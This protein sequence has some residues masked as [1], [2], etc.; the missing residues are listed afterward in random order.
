MSGFDHDEV[1]TKIGRW[2]PGASAGAA[3][4]D[5]FAFAECAD[6]DDRM[7]DR[8]YNEV[9]EPA[10]PASE[11][12]DRD[13]VRTTWRAPSP[14]VLS[15]LI[16]RGNDPVACAL[17]EWSAA[18]GVLLLSYLAV[19]SDLRGHGLGGALLGEVLPRWH[20]ALT[21]TAILAEVEDPRHHEV[22]PH[23]DPVARLRFYERAGARLLPFSYF[24]PS[25]APGLPR[26]RGMLLICLDARRE[27]I[28]AESVA[29]F[30]DE[31]MASAESAEAARTDPEYLGLR[32]QVLS[33]PGGVPLWPLSRVAEV[34]RL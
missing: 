31:Y 7:F 10:F 8:F 22:G 23:G 26:V 33:W 1:M 4:P 14:G 11:L 6:L 3:D 24:Q 30:L 20:E 21:P 17:G 19:R 29:R 27:V 18:S 34:P 32:E 25:L 5:G 28:P 2:R 16:L 9:L 15:T 13:A 12:Y